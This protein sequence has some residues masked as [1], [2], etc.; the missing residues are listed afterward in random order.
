MPMESSRGPGPNGRHHEGVP[1]VP[2]VSMDSSQ[3]PSPNDRHDEGAPLVPK[4]GLTAEPIVSSQSPSPNGRHHEGVPF[5]PKVPMDSSRSPSPNGWAREG[6][7]FVVPKD[8]LT[9]ELG[10]VPMDSSQRVQHRTASVMRAMSSHLNR[11]LGR[12][13]KKLGPPARRP[14]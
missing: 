11:R 13:P 14:I 1:F 8:R 12:K 10:K 9:A 7:L 2:K 3:S 6:V 4:D 5:V